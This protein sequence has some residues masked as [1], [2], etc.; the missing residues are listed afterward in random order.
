LNILFDTGMINRFIHFG[1]ASLTRVIYRQT[2]RRS[3]WL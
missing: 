2:D 1:G 3:G